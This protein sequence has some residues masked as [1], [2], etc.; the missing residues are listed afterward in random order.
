[1]EISALLLQVSRRRAPRGC[2]RR[3]MRLA[4]LRVHA[5]AA[6]DHGRGL[7]VCRRSDRF[8]TW[9]RGSRGV[10]TRARTPGRRTCWW[11]SAHVSLCSR[12]GEGSGLAGAGLSA[13]QKVVSFKPAGMAWAW[14]GGVSSPCSCTALRWRGQLPFIKVHSWRL[15]AHSIHP[16][17]RQVGVSQRR[18]KVRVGAGK[19]PKGGAFFVPGGD[20]RTANNW[21][22]PNLA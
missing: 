3:C 15:P 22:R 2:P 14:M 13:A 17:G 5:D 6:E 10:N 19:L 8:L 16:L 4:D 1:V 7:R 20:Q 21:T 11:R 9:S 18:M 12:G